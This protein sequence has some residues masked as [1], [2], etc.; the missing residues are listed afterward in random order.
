M[1]CNDFVFK[2]GIFTL[3]KKCTNINCQQLWC[4]AFVPSC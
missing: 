2:K 4:L 3:I 1:Y